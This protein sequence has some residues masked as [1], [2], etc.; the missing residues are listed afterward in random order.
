[1]K[2]LSKER[3]YIDELPTLI[4]NFT[5]FY[6]VHVIECSHSSKNLYFQTLK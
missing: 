6:H 2:R 1:M 4:M 5:T 3:L